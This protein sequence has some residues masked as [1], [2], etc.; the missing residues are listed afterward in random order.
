VRI[1]IDLA[2]AADW[3]ADMPTWGWV[4]AAAHVWYGAA[5]L[6]LRQFKTGRGE[7]FEDHEERIYAWVFSP[8]VLLAPAALAI[9][10][11]LTASSMG[12]VPPPWKT[13]KQ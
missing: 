3:L 7:I 4:A 10:L 13:R 6:F 12:L 1:E 8:L 2:R 11:S 9:W 5:G